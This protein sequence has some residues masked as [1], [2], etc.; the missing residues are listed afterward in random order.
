MRH[1]RIRARHESALATV[2]TA[3]KLGF[4]SVARRES[5]ANQQSAFPRPGSLLASESVRGLRG[6]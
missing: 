3:H 2:A 4:S 6:R 5:V 1:Q